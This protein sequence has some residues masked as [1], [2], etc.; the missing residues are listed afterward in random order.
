METI[1][2][3]V[4]IVILSIGIV[5]SRYKYNKKE[6]SLVNALIRQY[7]EA[8]LKIE[9]RD[10]FIDGQ[11][12]K[13]KAYENDMNTL[14]EVILGEGTIVDKYDKIKELLSLR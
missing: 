13:L 11:D 14:K 12:E 4:T 8:T 1:V 5:L 6:E 3:C 7:N 9:N 10:K 2:L